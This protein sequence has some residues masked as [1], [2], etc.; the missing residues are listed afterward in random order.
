MTETQDRKELRAKKRPS[1]GI[2]IT[3]GAQVAKRVFKPLE[4]SPRF[5]EAFG[6]LTPDFRIIVWGQSGHGKSNLVM[7]FA[8]ELLRL[9]PVLYL[10]LEEGRGAT[11][12]KLIQRYI[13]EDHRGHLRI[14]HADASYD[15]VFDYL[16]KPRTPA[17]V[18][19]DSLQYFD[20]NY[21]EYKALM[22]AFTRK[23][24]IFISHAKGKLPDGKTADK[25]RYDAGL[26]IHVDHDVAF[27]MHSRYGGNK[28][29]VIWEEGAKKYWKKD[30]KNLLNR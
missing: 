1:S 24:F 25:I 20:I 22:E 30:F 29:F 17:F 15:N 16:R 11:I 12:Q 5:R 10:S 4:L 23:G 8:A 6:D 2:R 28:N 18:I 9:G 13:P 3:T 26:K 21:R 27:V 7:Q 14:A 19:V